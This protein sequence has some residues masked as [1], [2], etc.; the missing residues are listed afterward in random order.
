MNEATIISPEFIEALLMLVLPLAAFL[1]LNILPQRMAAVSGKLVSLVFLIVFLLSVHLIWMRWG[2]DTIEYQLTWFYLSGTVHFAAGILLDMKTV[3]M[4]VVV[5]VISLLVSLFSISYMHNDQDERRY[6]ANLGLFVFSM[7]GIV[8][9]NNLLQLFCFWELVGLSSYLLINHWYRTGNP[10]KAATK[11]FVVNR[12]GDAAFLIGIGIAWTMFDSLSLTDLYS[13][14]ES[15]HLEAGIWMAGDKEMPGI[16]LSV[17]GI[18][19]FLGAAG[20]SAQFP[21]QAWLPDAMA[22]PTPVSALIHAATMVAAGV[23]LLARVFPLLSLE[24]MTF[25]AVT[26]AITAFMG[27]VAAMTQN[28]IKKVL[29][30]STIS[31]LGYMVMGMGVGAYDA[32]L[33]HLF[34]HAFFKAGLFLAAGA[35]IHAMHDLLKGDHHRDPQDMR[36]MGGLRKQLPVIFICYVIL[37]LA[38]VG[39]PFFSGFLS[40]EAIMSGSFA[41]ADARSGGGMSFYHLVPYTGMVTVALTAYYMGRQVYLVFLG[42]PATDR[43]AGKFSLQWLMTAP[44]V[45]LS[46]LSI[47]LIWSFNPLSFQNSW[48]FTNLIV[49]VI[50]VPGYPAGLQPLIVELSENNHL[51]VFILSSAMII[52]GL[53]LAFLRYRNGI[54]EQNRAGNWFYNLSSGNWWMDNLYYDGV[55]GPVKY[56][57]GRTYAMDRKVIDSL[58]NYLVV[59]GVLFSKMTG[60]FDRNIVDGLVHLVAAAGKTTGSIFRSVQGGNVQRYVAAAILLMIVLFWLIY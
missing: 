27:A 56:L 8:I 5:S 3:I 33:F 59:S 41:W 42:Q 10:P 13:G 58:L 40:K 36:N 39:I 48:F 28:D 32:S 6:F 24:A 46:L 34:T 29:A 22:G 38:L 44:V 18:C 1:G 57:A 47:G 23:F 21:F 11:A 14:M 60:W 52:T 45:I 19:L 25:I 49:P 55:A 2:M 43:V 12:V 54:P 15:S 35:V 20:K 50:Q 4:L 30:F 9:S 7:I 17:L 31:Q 53:G 16:W 51:L 37:S 26:G